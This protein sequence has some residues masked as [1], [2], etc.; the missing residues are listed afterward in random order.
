MKNRKKIIVVILLFVVV[1]LVGVGGYFAKLELDKRE[2]VAEEK[3]RTLKQEQF[4]EEKTF[5]PFDVNKYRQN[6]SSSGTDKPDQDSTTPPSLPTFEQTKPDYADVTIKEAGWIP[7]WDFNAGLTSLKTD[8]KDFD[9]ISPVWYS[10]NPDGSLDDKKNANF[11]DLIYFAKQNNIKVLPSIATFDPEVMKSILTSEENFNRHIDLLMNEVITYDFD[12]IDL[13]YEATYLEN[14]DRY[15]DFLTTLNSRLKERNKTLSV[16]VLSQ[17]GDNIVYPSLNETRKVQDWVEISKIADQI[18]IMTYDYT[19]TVDTKAGP[20]APIS[21]VEDVLKYA[22]RKI[23]KDKIWLGVHLYSYEWASTGGAG[24]YTYDVLP[25]VIGQN[26]E[27]FHNSQYS[28]GFFE[29][30]CATH[31]KCT[32]FFQTR[33]GIEDRHNLA[34]KYGIAGVSYWRVGREGGLLK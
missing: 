5:K 16:T 28:E 27:N 2:K 31:V 33:K 10:P 23:P 14:K 15:F 12:G 25:N 24:T 17:W 22:I 11:R 13:D 32:I 18:R 20:I 6:R 8:A 26:P 7:N 29:Y 19:T 4:Q 1:A 34:K 21:W 3:L 9:S 30:E